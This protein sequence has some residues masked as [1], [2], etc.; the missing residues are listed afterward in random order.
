[1]GQD[2]RSPGDIAD[3]AGAGGNVLQG[4]SAAGERREPAFPHAAQGT[5]Q[6]V[7]GAGID[8]EVPA[9][10]GVPDWDVN[11]DSGAVVSGASSAS[12]AM[13]SSRYR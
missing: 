11:A 2:E 3:H 12:T 1:M 10:G 7:A 5:E 9:V 8:I 6:G 13:T 4:A